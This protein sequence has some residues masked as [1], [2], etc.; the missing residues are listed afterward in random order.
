MFHRLWMDHPLRRYGAGPRQRRAGAL[1][2]MHV[3]DSMVG[4]CI[5]TGVNTI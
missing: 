3:M 1:T 2:R 5:A 4:C